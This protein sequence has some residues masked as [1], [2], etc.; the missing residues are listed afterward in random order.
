M[1]FIQAIGVMLYVSLIS[2]FLSSFEAMSV[3][4]DPL[5]TGVIILG[6]L[7][8]SAG[9]TGS[10]VF[11]Y[12]MYLALQKKMKEALKVLLLT[13]AWLLIIITAIILF[14]AF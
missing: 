4:S 9:I 13:F 7:V 8:L 12:P 10:M 5:L 3:L 2:F 1:A 6:L 14:V 11:G